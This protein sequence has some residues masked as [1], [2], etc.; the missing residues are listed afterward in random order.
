[1]K[2]FSFQVQDKDPECLTFGC[3][4]ENFDDAISKAEKAGYS[5]LLL[6]E[7]RELSGLELDEVV[8]LEVLANPFLGPEWLPIIDLLSP[9][10]RR[11]GVGQMWGLSIATAPYNW[12]HNEPG[13]EVQFLQAINEAD[14]SLHLEIGTSEV[15]RSNNKD[16]LDYLAFSNWNPPQ[17]GLPLHFKVLEP[18]WNP[19]YA[20][21]VAF[22]ALSTV[23]NVTAHDIFMLEGISSSFVKNNDLF[24]VGRWNGPF[25]IQ[26][27]GF[28]LKGIHELSEN[29]P[30]EETKARVLANAFPKD[31]N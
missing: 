2:V 22:Q 26:G 19:R 13:G 16:A 11:D 14:G 21:M 7:A 18:G 27:I 31:A 24:D 6:M 28:A 10:I 20:L 23:L 17:S 9:R 12:G 3:I 1:M 5:S 25:Q 15:T 30:D 8:D 29:E 4:A